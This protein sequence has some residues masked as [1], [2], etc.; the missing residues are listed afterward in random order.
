[1]KIKNNIAITG[2]IN[3][4]GEI[5]IIGGLDLK[6]RGG[7]MAGVKEFIIPYENE[8]DYKLFYDK[9][10]NELIIIIM[11]FYKELKKVVLILLRK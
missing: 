2:E 7:I 11:S 6:I 4:Q 9:L 5:K 3:I 8:R 1:M 10:E